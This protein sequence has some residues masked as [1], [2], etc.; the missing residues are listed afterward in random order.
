VSADLAS[1]K[2]VNLLRVVAARVDADGADTK[3]PAILGDK[4]ALEPFVQFEPDVA[5]GE[6]TIDRIVKD[7]PRLFRIPPAFLAPAY[8]FHFEAVVLDVDAARQVENAPRQGLRGV[9]LAPR[10]QR[11]RVGGFRLLSPRARQRRIYERA[12]RLGVTTVGLVLGIKEALGH[13]A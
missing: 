10:K 3:P 11:L 5:L 4:L 9:R 8:H 7:A 1:A 2:T 6:I 13:F 12:Q